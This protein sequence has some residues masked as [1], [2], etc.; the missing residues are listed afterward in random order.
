M[1][2]VALALVAGASIGALVVLGLKPDNAPTST[3]SVTSSWGSFVPEGSPNT[4]ADLIAARVGK[5]YRLPNGEQIVGVI[6]GPPTVTSNQPEG[7][8]QILVRAIASR[9]ALPTGGSANS[10]DI[11]TVNTTNALQ[12]MLCGY[13]PACSIATG[14]PTE[15]RAL[16]LR[17]EALELGLYT[18]KYI[19]N[20]DSIVV[21]LPPPYVNGQPAG[22]ATAVLLRRKD[23]TGLLAQRLGDTLDPKTPGIGMMSESDIAVVNEITVPQRFTVDYTQAQDGGAVLLLDPV[24]VNP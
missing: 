2:N 18:F 10:R 22:K 16:L 13:G 17:R 15:D 23:L 9:P 12:Y 7:S 1:I 14:T 5:Q 3:S 24:K 8:V 21:F 19:D 11:Q 20:I 4:K 6:A